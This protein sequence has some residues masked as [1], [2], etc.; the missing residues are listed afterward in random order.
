MDVFMMENNNDYCYSIGN[1]N[2]GCVE[3]NSL[4]CD[5]CVLDTV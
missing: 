1:V 4:V 3:K 5:D 2:D